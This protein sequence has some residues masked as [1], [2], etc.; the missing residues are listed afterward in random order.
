MEED[1]PIIFD[2]GSG[3][4]KVGFGGDDQPKSVFETLVGKKRNL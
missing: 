1:I 4:T 2:C 3:F